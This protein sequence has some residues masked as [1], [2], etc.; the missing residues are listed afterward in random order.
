MGS[1]KSYF[2]LKGR[3]GALEYWRLQRRLSLVF[4]IVFVVTIFATMAGGWLGAIPSVFV[5]P[6]LVAGFC[7]GVRRLHDRGKSAWWLAVFALVPI[8]IAG[9]AEAGDQSNAML[10]LTALSVPIMLGLV[11]WSWIEFAGP[12]QK[13][14]NRYGPDPK[15]A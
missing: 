10:V 9:F 3:L 2:T 13:G 8:L 11:I 5:A 4:V 15:A 1:P 12:G 6:L 14:P 7:F